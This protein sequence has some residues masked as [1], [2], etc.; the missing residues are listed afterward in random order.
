MA[1]II[2][3]CEKCGRVCKNAGG[4]TNHKKSCDINI[5][6]VALD[7]IAD[8]L[9]VFEKNVNKPVVEKA[10]DD[11]YK[12]KTIPKP[13]RTAVWKEQFGSSMGGKC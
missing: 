4:L 12:K 5:A 7:K 6:N 8:R 2:H 11:I 10:T 1:E 3:K 13:L 9:E